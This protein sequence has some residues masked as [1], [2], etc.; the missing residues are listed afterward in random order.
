MK[1]AATSTIP[2]SLR[3]A[4]LAC[5][6]LAIASYSIAVALSPD[7]RNDF[8]T[9]LFDER[10]ARA[11]GHMLG[12]GIAL[13]VG[14]F[15]FSRRLRTRHVGLHR[16]LGRVYGIAV[17]AG[18]AAAI[19]LAVQADG[20]LPGRA[21]FFVLGALWLLTTATAI[22]RIRAGDRFAHERWMMRSY[23][24]CLAAVSLRILLPLSQVAGIDFAIAYPIIAWACWVPNLA[25][26]EWMVRARGL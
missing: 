17:L 7:W 8:V 6:A 13:A 25:V 26:A 21:G 16:A 20:G 11:Y 18:G 5:M 9:R 22:A 15:Q 23:A 3:W 1:R 14:A 24:L 12:G 10:P 4:V 19:G 2:G